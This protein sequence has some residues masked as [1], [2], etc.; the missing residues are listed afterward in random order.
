MQNQNDITHMTMQTLSNMTVIKLKQ[1][2]REHQFIGFSSYK[3]KKN[4]VQFIYDRIQLEK[5]EII[6]VHTKMFFQTKIT[7]IIQTD[8]D[9]DEDSQKNIIQQLHTN[10]TIVGIPI[11][12]IITDKDHI[13]HTDDKNKLCGYI[14]NQTLYRIY[15]VFDKN[16]YSFIIKIYQS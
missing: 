2:C 12:D 15:W 16:N 13:I 10:A 3:N 9:I 14:H 6:N 4:L 11:T 1:L 8:T 7:I 5:T